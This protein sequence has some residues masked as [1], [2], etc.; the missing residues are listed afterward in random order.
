MEDFLVDPLLY[1]DELY[2]KLGLGT[3][4][5]A[6]KCK[7]KYLTVQEEREKNHYAVPE[8]TIRLVNK[9]ASGISERLGYRKKEAAV[10][11]E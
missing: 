1:M 8:E 5:H 3:F 9:H 10:P 11:V 4:D 7:E 2:R 6:G